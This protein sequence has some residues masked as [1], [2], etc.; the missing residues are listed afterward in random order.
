MVESGRRRRRRPDPARARRATRV[1]GRSGR[2]C[3]SR[4][5]ALPAP[6]RPHRRAQSGN[7]RWRSAAL[8]E[9]PAPA[10]GTHHRPAP[11]WQVRPPS[12]RC[13]ASPGLWCAR[14][15]RGSFPGR[16]RS[17]APHTRPG[18]RALRSPWREGRRAGQLLPNR[19]GS[20]Q[21]STEARSER[22]THTSKGAAGPSDCASGR[23]NARS[24]DRSAHRRRVP[25]AASARP[26]PHPARS[27]A[28]RRSAE[29]RKSRCP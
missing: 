4:S 13:S 3:R 14:D 19:A 17:R 11:A 21:Q 10:A 12:R 22:R 2:G 15:S 7:S 28:G 6:C 24:A 5:P 9:S 26:V 8:R 23:S 27:P 25:R 29:R 20:R 18:W 16:A 1:G